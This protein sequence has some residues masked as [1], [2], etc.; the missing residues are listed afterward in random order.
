MTAV[1]GSRPG[2]PQRRGVGLDDR[3]G[4]LA[5]DDPHG[6]RARVG[7]VELG[8]HRHAEA[9]PDGERHLDEK[10]VLGRR[11]VRRG[12]AQHAQRGERVGVEP[13]AVPRVEP[14]GE[15]VLRLA[16]ADHGGH[17]RDAAS[18][19]R[20]RPEDGRVGGGRRP[21]SSRRTQASTPSSCAGRVRQPGRAVR[22]RARGRATRQIEPAP[23]HGGVAERGPQ[24]RAGPRA[25]VQ[26]TGLVPPRHELP[27]GDDPAERPPG[28][29]LTAPGEHVPPAGRALLRA[30]QG[31]PDEARLRL[32][33]CRL[34]VGPARPAQQPQRVD[35]TALDHIPRLGP[36]GL[37]SDPYTTPVLRF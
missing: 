3:S 25:D 37:L 34:L 17:G 36:D 11:A 2:P 31:G 23:V 13:G 16:P 9:A 35:R 21:A 22:C 30:A 6:D 20:A 24:V 4:A 28:A 33:P 8:V 19:G 7:A 18:G 27:A 15:H 10:A 12:R 32:S 1:R 5:V 14:V 26:R 29:D